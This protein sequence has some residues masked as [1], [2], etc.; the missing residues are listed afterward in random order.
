MWACS[1][2]KTR[3][4]RPILPTGWRKPQSHGSTC[5]KQLREQSAAAMTKGVA[6][7]ENVDADVDMA[8]RDI[9]RVDW[10]SNNEPQRLLASATS[11]RPPSATTASNKGSV[12]S[13]RR[14]TESNTTPRSLYGSSE[15]HVRSSMR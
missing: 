15:V 7:A 14:R 5:A 4:S 9:E 3:R 13:K 1:Q 11:H 8:G 2:E 10:Q 6:P 12:F